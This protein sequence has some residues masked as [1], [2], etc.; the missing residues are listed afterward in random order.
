VHCFEAI[1]A[2]CGDSFVAETE[3]SQKSS[4]ARMTMG[5]TLRT[6]CEGFHTSPTN[7]RGVGTSPSKWA[8]MVE[9]LIHRGIGRYRKQASFTQLVKLLEDDL[10]TDLRPA[11]ATES[12]PI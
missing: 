10:S 2:S 7:R 8:G 11:P 3:G 4:M 12:Q 5:F 1:K 6:C 9:Q